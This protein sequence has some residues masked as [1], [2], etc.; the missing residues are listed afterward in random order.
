MC[1]ARPTCDMRSTMLYRIA[2]TVSA[3]VQYF[4]CSERT[5]LCAA[6]GS[7]LHA[8]GFFPLALR[9]HEPIT[10]AGQGNS[11]IHRSRTFFV[12]T[13]GQL[14]LC[15]LSSAL[16]EF[17]VYRKDESRHL[18]QA[19]CLSTRP[20]PQRSHVEPLRRSAQS[21]SR[22]RWR[23]GP[24]ADPDALKWTHSFK[25]TTETHRHHRPLA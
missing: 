2:P 9:D 19:L 10:H 1:R 7:P 3:F 17:K 24:R 18:M 16:F 5:A 15:H 21:G 22:W 14:P 8:H 11:Q 12:C 23:H 20:T 6:K 4:I 13:C 25:T